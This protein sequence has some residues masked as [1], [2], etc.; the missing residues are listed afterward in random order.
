MLERAGRQ[1]DLL[2]VECTY[3]HNIECGLRKIFGLVK[4]KKKKPTAASLE[5]KTTVGVSEEFGGG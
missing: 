4:K 3:I 5:S 1:T 2:L